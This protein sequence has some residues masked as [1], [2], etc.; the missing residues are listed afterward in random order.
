MRSASSRI[1][2]YSSIGRCDC[3]KIDVRDQGSPVKHPGG[4][5]VS[6]GKQMSAKAKAYVVD[7]LFLGYLFY[8]VFAGASY[9]INLNYRL[10]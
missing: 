8:R 7:C 6:Q 4:I 1:L 10:L 9:L 5:P 2:S 3:K